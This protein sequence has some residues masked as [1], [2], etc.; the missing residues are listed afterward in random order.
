ME[1][2][3]AEIEMIINSRPLTNMQDDIHEILTPSHLLLG[4]RLLSQYGHTASEMVATPVN[5]T[6]ES[7]R[8]R[9]DYL[10]EL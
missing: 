6:V 10:N 4:R 7:S 2:V 3:L 5:C 8:R 9:L 1:T